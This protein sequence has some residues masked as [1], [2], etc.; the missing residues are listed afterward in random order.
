MITADNLRVKKSEIAGKLL[1][2]EA[3][4]AMRRKTVKLDSA[5]NDKDYQ[6]GG[7]KILR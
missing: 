3:R 4:T 5:E 1:T 7:L 2:K 6:V